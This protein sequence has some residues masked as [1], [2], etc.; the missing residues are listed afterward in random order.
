MSTLAV[1]ALRVHRGERLVVGDVSFTLERGETLVVVG[2]NGAGKTSLLEGLLGLV[3][4]EGRVRYGNEVV[5]TLA[6]RSS[7][8][9][10]LP[11]GAE[12]A[13]EVSVSTLVAHAARYGGMERAEVT[14]LA[15]R[16]GLAALTSAR[17]GELSRGEKQRLQLFGALCSRR[18][19]VVMDEPLATFDP[20][21]LIE[22]LAV[23]RER[24]SS[25]GSLLLTVHQLSDAE[26][27][28][29]RVLILDGGKA[30]ACGSMDTLRHEA[31]LPGASLEE[32]FLHLLQGARAR[33]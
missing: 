16:L 13:W 8:F 3:P 18:P 17:S 15:E 4:A 22:V 1:E 9:S 25:G 32:I 28:A 20:M 30:L 29:S 33:A 11:D 31:G 23:L 14:Q 27:I 6:S 19:V 5:H 7:V 12:P 24:A 10:Y 2:P 26:K 21:Q